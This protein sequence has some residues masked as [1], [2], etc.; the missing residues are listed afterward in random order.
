MGGR[1]RDS[2]ANKPPGLPP[3]RVEHLTGTVRTFLLISSLSSQSLFDEGS[4]HPSFEGIP[5]MSVL[6]MTQPVEPCTRMLRV[7]SALSEETPGQRAF[8]GF[9]MIFA[10][11]QVMMDTRLRTGAFISG[12]P[13]S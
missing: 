7:V 6:K 13:C 8:L 1:F 12:P 4:D 2:D 5:R 9:G 3:L 10:V 11:C